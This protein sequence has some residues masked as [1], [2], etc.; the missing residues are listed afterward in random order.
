MSLP[1]C[2]RC[3]SAVNPAR[4]PRCIGCGLD[5]SARPASPAPRRPG[6]LEEGT[7]DSGRTTGVM[8][9]MGILGFLGLLAGIQ[10]P[11]LLILSS[12][13]GLLGVLG[14]IGRIVFAGPG[15]T[16]GSCAHLTAILLLSGVALVFGL[17]LL[18]GIACSGIP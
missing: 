14:V 16:G 2:P 6:A 5:V 18:L 13:A 1:R 10:S 4:F 3:R 7:R 11:L 17:C 9:L 8:A 12:I 15:S